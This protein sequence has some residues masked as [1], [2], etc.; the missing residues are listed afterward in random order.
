M[1]LRIRLIACMIAASSTACARASG[2]AATLDAADLAAAVETITEQDMYAR[3]ALLSDDA[4][5][6][7][8]TPSPGLDSA[9]SYVAREFQRLGLEPAGDSAGYIQRYPFTTR[10]VQPTATSLSVTT[11]AGASQ[12]RF[13]QDYYMVAGSAP[14]V[15]AGV[16]FA[17]SA[18]PDGAAFN[19]QIAAVA[20]PGQ[21]DRAFRG[22]V[23]S[24]RNAA[25]TGGA[26]ALLVLLDSAVDEAAIAEQVERSRTSSAVGPVI[27]VI[28]LRREA[29]QRLFGN[30]AFAAPSTTALAGA[31]LTLDAQPIEENAFPPNAI[32]ILRGS[33]PTLRDT[34]VVVS[35]HMDHIGIGRP[36]ATGDSINNGAD[37]DASGTSAILEVAEAFASLPQAPARSIVFLAVSGEEKG[38][39]GSRWFSDHPTI[40]LERTVAN[41]NI[42]MISRNAPD[43]IV[44]I[45]Q[46]FSSLG[47]LAQRIASSHPELGIVLAQDI[48]PEQRFFFRSD[49]FNFAR[50]EVPAIFFFNGV[51]DDYH[52]VSDEV[53][54]IDVD[55]ATRITRLVFWLAEAIASDPQAPQWTPDGLAQVRELTR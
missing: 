6:G 3:I 32:G 37:D 41:I 46:D 21:L 9:A 13:G 11:G 51:H 14:R 18:I 29:A 7:R 39:L 16:V 42:D 44:A 25:A 31:S 2:P 5:Q 47:P 34:Y 40:P 17:G 12:A 22:A 30:D 45:G 19:G 15:Q 23:T 10:T 28:Y 48:W 8:D 20:I 4:M 53:D 50:K 55:K 33:D 24:A 1:A 26:S 49:H 27:P 52:Q 35:A 36:D 54:S 38:L 43:T